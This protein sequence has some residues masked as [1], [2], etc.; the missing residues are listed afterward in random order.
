MN[1]PR[2]ALIS[3]IHSNHHALRAVLNHIDAVG[4]DG[5]IFLGDYVSDFPGARQVISLLHECK[6]KYPCWFIRGNREDYLLAHRSDPA[7]V[8][9][10]GSAHGSL[11][12]TY[13]QLTAED[14]DFFQSLPIC[15]VIHPPQGAPL[16]AFHGS[17]ERSN[18]SIFFDEQAITHFM[19]QAE[20]S[21]LVCG[22]QHLVRTVCRLGRIL[23][24]TGSTGLPDGFGGCAQFAYLTWTDGRWLPQNQIIP[25]DVEAALAEFDHSGLSAMGGWFT[26][27]VRHMARTGLNTTARLTQRA[28]ELARADGVS[29]PCPEE[30]YRQAA[31]DVGL[32]QESRSLL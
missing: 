10:S 6:E 24:F 8:W 14:L 11:L 18:Q 26:A 31:Q 30:Y 5:L 22:H 20:T 7:S 3:D 32:P 13:Q 15:Q 16:T 29:G 27:A 9:Q 21:L 4:A 12:Y 25:Y 2:L 23:N 1:P 28:T 19:Q 17:P